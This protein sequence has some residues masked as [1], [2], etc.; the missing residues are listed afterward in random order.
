MGDLTKNFSKSEFL[1][2]HCGW[3]DPDPMLVQTLQIIRDAVNAPVTV[4]SGCRCEEHNRA[5]GGVSDSQ[6]LV[7]K[8]ADIS[9]NG[10]TAAYLLKLIQ[11]LVRLNVIYIG[12][13]YKITNNSIHVDVREPVSETVR[14][15]R[16]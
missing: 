3:G 9:V 14:K 8:A 1:C 5:V 11:A 13:A 10:W 2:K 6:H 16:A 15:W 4:I 7:C 12:Y